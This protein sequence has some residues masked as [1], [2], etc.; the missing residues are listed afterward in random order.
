[1]ELVLVIQARHLCGAVT[2]LGLAAVVRLRRACHQCGLGYPFMVAKYD[3]IGEL[4]LL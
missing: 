3:T 2:S 1:M 4:Y